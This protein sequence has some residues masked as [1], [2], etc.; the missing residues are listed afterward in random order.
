MYSRL[1]LIAKRVLRPLIYRFPPVMIWP[2]RLYIW[3]DV[4]SRT[5]N[6][7]GD[8]LEVGC[9]L[10]GT[11]AVSV[12][13]LDA[14]GSDRPYTVI[15]TFSGFNEGQFKNEVRLGANQRLANEFS[16]NSPELTRWVLD[17]HGGKRVK[18]VQGDIVKITDDQI[19]MRISACLL[20]VDLEEPIYE[21]LKR[22]YPRLVTGGIIA[23]DDCDNHEGGYKAKIGYER[24]MAENG[25][26]PEYKYGMGLVAKPS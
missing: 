21:G 18:I 3:L 1:K 13:M 11:A 23:V 20:D 16:S 17:R 22:L 6:V 26:T 14:I 9:Y 5:K 15:D 19:P 2:H 10:G 8:V 4:L 12:R 7:S 25:F 24:F